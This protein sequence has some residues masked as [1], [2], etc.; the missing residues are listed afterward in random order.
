[1]FVVIPALVKPVD[2][3][4]V[5]VGQAIS[6]PDLNRGVR[7]GSYGFRLVISKGSPTDFDND[8]ATQ[9]SEKCTVE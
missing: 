2:P 8:N 6:L 1:M 3:D 5:D 9:K 7:D 4:N